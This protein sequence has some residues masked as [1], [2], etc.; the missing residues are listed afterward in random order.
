MLSLEALLHAAPLTLSK[1]LPMPL[2]Q[3]ALE[4]LKAPD[5]DPRVL[6][7]LLERDP[8]LA[9]HLTVEI[10]RH[11]G[12][13]IPDLLQGIRFGGLAALESRLVAMKSERTGL[14]SPLSMLLR[15]DLLIHSLQVATCSYFLALDIGYRQPS[16]AFVAGLLH[17]LGLGLLEAY[18]PEPLAEALRLPPAEAA[19]LATAEDALLGGN[20]AMLGS[21]LLEHWQFPT[22]VVAAVRHHHA[23]QE[24]QA[25]QR[26]SRLLHLAEVGVSTLQGAVPIE[27]EAIALDELSLA[28]LRL[29]PERLKMLAERSLEHQ[30]RHLAALTAPMA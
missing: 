18:S 2:A 16:E 29:S 28:S 12:R 13:R 1:A 22:G 19:A 20:H 4:R 14:P 15:G 24:A 5:A 6:A 3:E 30:R 27:D 17:D 21:R 23:P 9:E 26:L 8:E 7:T 25:G 11:T 10:A